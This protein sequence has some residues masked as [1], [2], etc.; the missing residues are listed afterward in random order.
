MIDHNLNAKPKT[1]K[2][3]E[4]QMREYLESKAKQKNKN[5]S[6]YTKARARSIK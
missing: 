6:L 5:L 1:T 4:T 2:L 3:L